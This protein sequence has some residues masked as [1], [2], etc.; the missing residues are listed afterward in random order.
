VL[1]A[2]YIQKSQQFDR[3]YRGTGEQWSCELAAAMVVLAGYGSCESEA[4]ADVIQ[5]QSLAILCGESR[6][7]TE[8][9]V[10]L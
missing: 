1:Q 9:M 10:D 8:K 6:S 7:D 3:L 4:A 5:R 2:A